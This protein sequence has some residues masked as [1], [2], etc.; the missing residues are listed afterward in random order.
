LQRH[1]KLL[2]IGTDFISLS[3]LTTRLQVPFQ[4]CLDHTAEGVERMQLHSELAADAVKTRLAGYSTLM[5]IIETGLLVLQ[6]EQRSPVNF[7]QNKHSG[8]TPL[9][10]DSRR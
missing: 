10:I 9:V 2:R 5:T 6:I 8:K 4:L 1:G 3:E 7:I